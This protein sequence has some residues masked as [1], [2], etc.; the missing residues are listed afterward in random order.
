MRTKNY[1]SLMLPSRSVRLLRHHLRGT[2]F[3]KVALAEYIYKLLT[4][5]QT[6][7]LVKNGGNVRVQ[8]RGLVFDIPRNDITILPTVLSGEYEEREFDLLESRLRR[9]SAFI[10]VGAN[11]GLYSVFAM[12]RMPAGSAA[13][14]FE[15]NTMIAELFRGN[16]G[17]NDLFECSVTLLEVALADRPYV[18]S[19]MESK[20]HGTGRLAG[21]AEF[22]GR[23]GASLVEVTTL[24]AVTGALSID[25]SNSVVKI[26]VEGFEPMVVMGGRDWISKWRPAMLIELCGENSQ[27]AGVDWTDATALLAHLYPEVEVLGPARARYRERTEIALPKVLADGRLHNLWFVSDSRGD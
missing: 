24:D 21:S 3:Q 19:W 6:R 27:Q 23:S 18:A 1:A 12:S 11:V 4:W 7:S 5:V 16:L 10:D 14:A 9:T 15:P 13:I 26:D 20:Y 2:R 8:F 22:A 25:F 17:L